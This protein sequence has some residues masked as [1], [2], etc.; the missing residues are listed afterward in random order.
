M[1]APRITLSPQGLEL[2]RIVAGVWRMAEW[3]WSPAQRRLWIEG[4]LELGVTTFDHADIYGGYT[5]ESL[6]GEVLRQSPSLRGRMELVSKCG[7]ALT[8]GNR[9]ANRLKH[10]N[11][12]R[13]Y[14]IASVELS[15]SNLATDQL[16]LLLIH[17]PDPLM[18]AD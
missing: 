4:C 2:S 3:N 9:P 5:I 6:F 12:T 7:I 14:I 16:D 10:Y 11:T 8:H 1:L 17:R 15:L 18:D 13:E